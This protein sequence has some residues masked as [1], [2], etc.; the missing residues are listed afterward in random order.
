MQDSRK[1][2][3]SKELRE[4]KKARARKELILK[5]ITYVCL[6]LVGVTMVMPFLWMVSTSLTSYGHAIALGYVDSEFAAE[7][8]P[9]SVTARREL[10]GRIVARPFFRQG[11]ARKPLFE[12][13]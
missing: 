13:L 5:V 2:A 6:A 9:V 11:T 12:F 8:I 7:G 4:S 10:S 3:I 1:S